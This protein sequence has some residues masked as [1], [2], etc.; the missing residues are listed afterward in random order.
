MKFKKDGKVFEEIS[1]ARSMFCMSTENSNGC[2][3][4]PLHSMEKTYK[5][6]CTKFCVDFP[7]EAA[8]IMGFDVVKDESGPKSK[9]HICDVLGVEVGEEFTIAGYPNREY[10]R[11][12]VHESG[13][14]WEHQANGMHHKIGSTALCWIINHSEAIKHLPRLT[15][16]ELEICRVLGAKWVTRD[17]DKKVYICGTIFRQKR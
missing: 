2:I 12:F 7:E 4:C 6:L 10:D 9:P 3:T 13:T 15:D 5:T 17:S 14:V 11:L 8:F 1:E 16:K